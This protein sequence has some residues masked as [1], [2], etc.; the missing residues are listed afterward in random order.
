MT[1]PSFMLYVLVGKKTVH[2]AELIK[3]N[4][5][6]FPVI[7]SPT[8]TLYFFG[9]KYLRINNLLRVKKLSIKTFL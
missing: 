2:I 4:F 8:A 9:L 6:S 1:L 5:I 7:Y 3:E